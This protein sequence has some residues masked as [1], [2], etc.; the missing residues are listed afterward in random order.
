MRHIEKTAEPADFTEWKQQGDENW[1]PGWAD[2]DTRPIKQ[3]VKRALLDEQGFLCCYCEVRVDEDHGHIEHIE[4]RHKRPD[5]ALLY[6]NMLY[7]CPDTPRGQ[8]T[9]CGHARKP[10]DPVPVSPLD[11]D[12]ESRF[13]YTGTGDMLPRDESDADAGETVRILNLN[14]PTLRRLRAGVYQEVADAQRDS[15]AEEFRRWMEIELQR[16]QW[17]RFS[18]FWATKR[19]VAETAG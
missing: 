10:D 14:E 8:P 6:T 16:D 12:C 15:S 2:F 17:G 1:N 5:L 4:T 7:C 11:A 3:T 19:Y 13:V 18:P 9:T